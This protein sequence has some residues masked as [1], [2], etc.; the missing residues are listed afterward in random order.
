[1]VPRIALS[2]DFTP[3]KHQF[4]NIDPKQHKQYI[5]PANQPF[6]L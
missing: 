2:C 5:K 6:T 3:I 1:M 4:L